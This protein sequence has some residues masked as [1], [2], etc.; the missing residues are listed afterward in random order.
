MTQTAPTLPDLARPNVA[1]AIEAGDTAE[2]VLDI[3]G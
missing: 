2:C 1:V 3:V